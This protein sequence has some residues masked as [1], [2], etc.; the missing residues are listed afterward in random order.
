V[1]HVSRKELKCSF[2]RRAT[3]AT[4]GNMKF[5][6]SRLVTTIVKRVNGLK[7]TNDRSIVVTDTHKPIDFLCNINSKRAVIYQLEFKQGMWA[8]RIRAVSLAKEVCSKEIISKSDP[9]FWIFV[10]CLV[11]YRSYR[12]GVDV[13]L[14]STWSVARYIGAIWW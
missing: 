10:S 13:Y 5:A 8:I 9:N 2:T 12:H 7:V 1:H 11:I 14:L 4:F 6:Y 3:L